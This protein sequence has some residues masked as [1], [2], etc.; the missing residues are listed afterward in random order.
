[1][2]TILI[3]FIAFNFW[4]LKSMSQT[5][6]DFAVYNDLKTN[7]IDKC[8]WVK[9]DKNLDLEG[10]IA[11]KAT[12]WDPFREYFQYRLERPITK[13]KRYVIE[14]TLTNGSIDGLSR[15]CHCKLGKYGV[16]GLGINFKRI[17]YSQNTK[18]PIIESSN[19]PVE[20]KFPFIFSEDLVTL[21]DT[22]TVDQPQQFFSF[23]YFGKYGGMKHPDFVSSTFVN[24][25][26]VARYFIQEI[27]LYEIDKLDFQDS[28]SDPF[29]GFDNHNIM[30]SAGN[31]DLDFLNLSRRDFSMFSQIAV[32]DIQTESI[33]LEYQKT[34]LA[35]Q[36]DL[37][38]NHEKKSKRSAQQ[39][40]DR[41]TDDLVIQTIQDNE[42]VTGTSKRQ[43]KK[44]RD[45]GSIGNSSTPKSKRNSKSREQKIKSPKSKREKQKKEKIVESPSSEDT[46]SSDEIAAIAS[47]TFLVD[48]TGSM[49]DGEEEIL[50]EVFTNQIELVSN[51]HVNYNIWVFSDEVRELARDADDIDE[52]IVEE[53]INNIEQNPPTKFKEGLDRAITSARERFDKDQS[54]LVIVCSDFLLDDS[55][56]RFT[57]PYKNMEY[58]EDKIKKN[59]DLTFVAFHYNTPGS[60][61]NQRL[62]NL[63]NEGSL[64]YYYVPIDEVQNAMKEIF[65]HHFINVERIE[66]EEKTIRLKTLGLGR[67]PQDQTKISAKNGRISFEVS[68]W[69]LSDEVLNLA[70]VH[71]IEDYFWISKT[72]DELYIRKRNKPFKKSDAPTIEFDDKDIVIKF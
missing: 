46:Y 33:S 6:I 29:G 16:E 7:S 12:S 31:G 37:V 52:S 13:D 43:R 32:Q 2:K 65:S 30:A 1:M 63:K 3:L 72:D 51:T 10:F 11:I 28:S 5:T 36:T 49:D 27:K 22:F 26:E 67:D 35:H 34:E 47:A 69:T 14:V 23:G 50:K 24:A 15:E 53:V 19:D 18:L 21:R 60:E 40:K 66:F 56:F 71:G 54:N 61:Q 25:E 17:P 39:N 55:K 20:V 8:K 42:K 57:D 44:S 4:G 59:S 70:R 41:T 38:G 9:D 48:V 62:F 68:N 58:L 45:E 64:R